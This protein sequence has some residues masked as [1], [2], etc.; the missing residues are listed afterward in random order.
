MARHKMKYDPDAQCKALVKRVKDL[1]IKAYQGMTSGPHCI[2]CAVNKWPE[3]IKADPRGSQDSDFYPV[4]SG[5]D[6]FDI[7]RGECCYG[8]GPDH[9]VLSGKKITAEARAKARARQ[10]R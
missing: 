9:Y 3:D 8:H 5:G 1:G 4:Y 10:G 6:E 7:V 2:K